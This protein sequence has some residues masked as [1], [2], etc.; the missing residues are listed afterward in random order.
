M[1][2][3]VTFPGPE[4]EIESYDVDDNLRHAEHFRCLHTRIDDCS[5]MSMFAIQKWKG[6][7]TAKIHNW[8][9]PS[10]IWSKWFVT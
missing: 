3:I 4:P 8:P 2:N 6:L 5:C 10:T 9:S 7:T 1:S